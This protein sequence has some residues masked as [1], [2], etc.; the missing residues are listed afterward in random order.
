VTVASGVSEVI[1]DYLADVVDDASGPV[2]LLRT[3]ARYSVPSDSW[4]VNCTGHLA[5][6]NVE[7]VPYVSSSGRTM[8]INLTSTTFLTPGVSA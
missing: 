4:V 8:S 5:P 1:R 7:H 3:G 2:M 6:R